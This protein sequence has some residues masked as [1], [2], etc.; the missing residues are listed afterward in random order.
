VTPPAKPKRSSS[1]L[2]RL[3]FGRK[4]SDSPR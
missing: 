4:A 2:R 3:S 1:M